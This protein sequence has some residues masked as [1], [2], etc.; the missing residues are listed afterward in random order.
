MNI[1]M[2]KAVHLN[3]QILTNKLFTHTHTH[4]LLNVEVYTQTNNRGTNNEMVGA[5]IIHSDSAQ[6]RETRVQ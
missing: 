6:R 1:H 2:H 4:T 3:T 5:V